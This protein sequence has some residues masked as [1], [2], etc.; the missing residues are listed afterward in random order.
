MQLPWT[1]LL[2]LL[3]ANPS[4]S[5][6]ISPPAGVLPRSDAPTKASDIIAAIMPSSTSCASASGPYASDCRT[7]AQAADPLIAAMQAYNLTSAGQIAAVLALVGLESADLK[8]KHN[9]SPGRVGQGTSAM[10]MPDNVAAYAGSI[11]ELAGGVAAAGGDPG[12]V[13]ELVVD[14]RYNFGAGPWW[15]TSRC[16]AGVVEGLKGASDAAW[17]AYMGCVGVSADDPD[18]RAYWERAK[19]AFGL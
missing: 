13:L 17:R 7:A 3:L 8:F 2:T 11:P 18:R 9:V 19:K 12:K 1:T 16:E 15:L 4:L 10:L 5:S 6:P 14:D